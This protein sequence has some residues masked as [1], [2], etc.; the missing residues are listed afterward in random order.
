MEERVKR[1]LR[2]FL[3]RG[4][5]IETEDHFARESLED[6]CLL[7]GECGSLRRNDIRDPRFE[8]CDQVEL[9]FAD[10]RAIRLD[11]SAFRL[12]QTEQDATFSK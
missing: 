7:F 12:V 4:V 5:G 6:T 11:Q 2:R 8:E 10:D 9:P 3:S 1:T